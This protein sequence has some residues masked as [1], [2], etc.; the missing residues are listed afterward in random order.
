[1]PVCIRVAH[2]VCF[3]SWDLSERRSFI[4]FLNAQDRA[5]FIAGL[6]KWD[7]ASVCFCPGLS[8]GFN[9]KQEGYQ[10]SGNHAQDLRRREKLQFQAL[11]NLICFLRV[12]WEWDIWVAGSGFGPNPP[13]ILPISGTDSKRA[14][15][16]KK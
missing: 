12:R 7:Q 10:D 5:L 15:I 9:K 2:G 16:L 6:N 8:G 3:P 13:C 1:M 4:F 14:S 11:K